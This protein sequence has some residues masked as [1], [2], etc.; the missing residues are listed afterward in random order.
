MPFTER[1]MLLRIVRALSGLK[2][3]EVEF[4]HH[5]SREMKLLPFSSVTKVDKTRLEDLYRCYRVEQQTFKSRN[6][7]PQSTVVLAPIKDVIAFG[8]ILPIDRNAMVGL[9]LAHYLASD[10]TGSDDVCDPSLCRKSVLK[11]I[12][13]SYW[14][15]V[16]NDI[17]LLN[18]LTRPNI[19]DHIPLFDLSDPTVVKTMLPPGGAYTESS[20][21]VYIRQLETA[22]YIFALK[23][24]NGH[25][26]TSLDDA[27]QRISGQGRLY[28][29]NSPWNY[30]QSL[31]D[32]ESISS[33]SQQR[34]SIVRQNTDLDRSRDLDN[35]SS[36]RFSRF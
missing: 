23:I 33:T 19:I 15:E 14:H 29:S 9:S 20:L 13:G 27:V 12:M 2:T 17:R 3:A 21:L 25:F 22:V 1:D 36:Y 10:L 32:T 6:S 30:A 5:L 11:W 34:R 8:D 35:S 28:P 24:S 18:D 31:G 26:C 7:A 16:T 4:R